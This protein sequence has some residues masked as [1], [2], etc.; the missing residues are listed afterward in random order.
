MALDIGVARL[1]YGALLPAIRR[2]LDL[3]YTAAGILNS[4]NLAAYLLGTLAAPALGR[5]IGMMRLAFWGHAAVALGFAISG[6]AGDPITL[7]VGRFLMGGGAGVGLVALFV[8]LLELSAPRRR[9][10]VTAVVWGGIGIA[11]VVTGAVLGPTLDSTQG[12]RNAF[13]LSAMIAAIVSA[14]LYFLAATAPTPASAEAAKPGQ[15]DRWRWMPLFLAYLMFGVGY[16][17]YSTFVGSRIAAAG[18]PMWIMSTNWIVLGM[19]TMTGSVAAVRLAASPRAA[20]FAL[21]LSLLCGAAGGALI[22]L[23][24]NA[25]TLLAA[26]LVGLGLSS[27]PAIVTSYVRQRS[28]ALT[29]ARLFSL[30]TASL[31]IGQFL[32]PMLAGL[33]AD[34]FGP[35]AVGPFAACAYAIGAIF[36]LW[37]ARAAPALF[38]KGA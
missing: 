1:T 17:A 10:T 28:T 5:R 21:I 14:R 13:Y 35:G 34:R 25:F 2:D 8:V 4:A 23:D 32:G 19:T 6:F 15:M 36:A 9:P 30:A 26:A 24:G 22:D 20:R 11:L 38:G 37:D 29:Y 3:T 31:G 18:A 12:W 33:V 16:I 7:G 27:T